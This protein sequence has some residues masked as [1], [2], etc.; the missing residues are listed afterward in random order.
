MAQL[1]DSRG[2]LRIVV[3]QTPKIWLY[4]ETRGRTSRGSNEYVPRNL[5]Q[6]LGGADR[7]NAI[8]LPFFW[9]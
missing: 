2:P 3:L 8:A 4:C 7:W 9:R 5:G 6:D 1:L